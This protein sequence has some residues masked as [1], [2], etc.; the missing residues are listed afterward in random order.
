MLCAALN[1]LIPANATL[2]A[3]VPNECSRTEFPVLH[4]ERDPST[5]KQ[6]A[7]PLVLSPCVL[8]PHTE[9]CSH[10]KIAQLI[11]HRQSGGTLVDKHVLQR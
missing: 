7:P 9:H 2:I 11:S 10:I 6:L 8:R 3:P 1:A 5:L 4:T